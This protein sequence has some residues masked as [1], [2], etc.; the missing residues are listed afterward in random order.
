MTGD[1][2]PSS[3]SFPRA[4]MGA[5]LSLLLLSACSSPGGGER[6]SA[7]VDTGGRTRAARPNAFQGIQT[8][9]DELLE[10]LNLKPAG[11]L[12]A[13]VSEDSPAQGAGLK[14]GDLILAVGG[15][16]I[17]SPADLSRSFQGLESEA[18][19][20]LE[21]LRGGERHA[22]EM[23]LAT[24]IGEPGPAAFRDGLAYLE[25]VAA[26][27]PGPSIHRQM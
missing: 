4:V 13:L 6:S 25:K 21:Y 19:L 14:P 23:A 11:A 10:E 17:G 1:R 26:Q 3:T 2:V 7:N 27:S 8:F 12:I 20:R 9:Q 15:S 5:S 18:K 24:R 22:V 16:P